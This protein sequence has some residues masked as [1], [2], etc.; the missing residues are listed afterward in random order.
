MNSITKDGKYTFNTTVLLNVTRNENGNVIESY[1]KNETTSVSCNVKQNL[2]TQTGFGGI[3]I[4][5]SDFTIWNPF[6]EWT[7]KY[8]TSWQYK[9]FPTYLKGKL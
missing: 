3:G 8:P 1:C 7:D 4:V 2:E 5:C 9:L 6:E